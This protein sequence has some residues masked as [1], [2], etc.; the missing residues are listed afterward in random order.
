MVRNTKLI[1]RKSLTLEKK[2][3]K[4]QE[5]LGKLLKQLRN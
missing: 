5:K 4:R 1:I 2:K 3:D